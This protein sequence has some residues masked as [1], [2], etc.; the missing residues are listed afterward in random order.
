MPSARWPQLRLGGAPLPTPLGPSSLCD[1]LWVR[2]HASPGPSHLGL[3]PRL[4]SSLPRLRHCPH[5]QT[6]LWPVE[7]ACGFPNRD[8]LASVDTQPTPPQMPTSLSSPPGHKNLW[9]AYYVPAWSD[10][11]RESCPHSA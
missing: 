4:R 2:G 6:H 8:L 7:L 1:Q 11:G 3:G 10:P 5:T 9:D